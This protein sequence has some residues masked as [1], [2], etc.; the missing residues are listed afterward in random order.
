[1]TPVGTTRQDARQGALR[2]TGEQGPDWRRMDPR[3]SARRTAV[4]REQGRRRLI[5]AGIALGVVGP[6]RRRVVPPPHAALLRPFGDGDRQR[7][8]DDGRRWWPRPGWPASRHC[9]TSNTGAVAARLEQL[10]W[11]RTA[12]GARVAGPTASTSP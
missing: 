5:I 3:I 1:M 9:S 6:R 2:R 8:R 4:I 12:D 10:P 7:A 11:V